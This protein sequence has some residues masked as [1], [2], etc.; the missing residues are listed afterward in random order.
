MLN[1]PWRTRKGQRADIS[2]LNCQGCGKE[3]SELSVMYHKAAKAKSRDRANKAT[4]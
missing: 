3:Q 1:P 4:T 2:L